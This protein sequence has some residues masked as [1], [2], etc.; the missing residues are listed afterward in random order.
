MAGPVERLAAAAAG[1][2]EEGPMAGGVEP[3]VLRL[4]IIAQERTYSLMVSV[5]AESG[6]GGSNC[7]GARRRSRGG[8]TGRKS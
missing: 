8:S 3:R 6:V 2:G 4:K 5:G 7:G 1:G